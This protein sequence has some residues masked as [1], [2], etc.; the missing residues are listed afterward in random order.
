MEDNEYEILKRKRIRKLLLLK[1]NDELKIISKYKSN[2]RINSKTIQELN[3][4]YN[5]SDILLHEKSTVYSNYIKTEETIISRSIS[6]IIR[7]RI[8]NK[9]I[10]NNN[11]NNNN[12]H[13]NNNNNNNNRKSWNSN[14]L[15]NSISSKNSKNNSKKSRNKKKEETKNSLIEICSVDEDSTS[16][17]ISFFPKKIELGRKKLFG[18]K[19][20]QRNNE[21]IKNYRKKNINSDKELTNQ[22]IFIKSTKL[23]PDINLHKLIEKITSI[24]NN[25][26]TEGIIRENIKK[27][28]QYCYQLRKK[29]KKVKKIVGKRD[30]S[31]RKKFKD[32]EKK[33]EREISN[34]R[35]RNTIT[36]KD[37]EIFKH[38]FFVNI[39]KK[40]ENKSNSRNEIYKCK[41]PSPRFNN[42]NFNTKKKSTGKVIKMTNN[43]NNLKLN[44]RY[45]NK[46]MRFFASIKSKEKI[47]KLQSMNECIGLKIM[48]KL[49]KKKIKKSYKPP[50]NVQIEE[51]IPTLSQIPKMMM[52][53]T[54]N[55]MKLKFDAN[56]I[57]DDNK[58]NNKTKFYKKSLNKNGSIQLVYSKEHKDK[59][60]HKYFNNLNNKKDKVELHDNLKHYKS[61]KKLRKYELLK[62]EN[63]NKNED[64]EEIIKLKKLSIIVDSRRKS[65]KKLGIDSPDR[66]GY[67]LSNY[68]NYNTNNNSTNPIINEKD[69]QVNRSFVKK[70]KKLKY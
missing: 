56:N 68:T 13:N 34:R 21:S 11:N 6:P 49:H 3:A 44:H 5:Q 14:N 35:R 15:R 42:N 60:E 38:S 23:N 53:S 55:E 31:S 17:V 46:N 69:E 52:K 16:P 47:H 63:E 30:S 25:E 2:I 20:K 26:S 37:K 41:S 51:P 29:K 64:N 59:G 50:E 27:L 67:R 22:N 48:N 58:K 19:S 36:N 40:M 12:N 28:R 24:K 70:N 39:Q 45:S 54:I 61:N 1:I 8:V 9:N 7:S 57:D 62:K 33:Q 10:I 4:V 43:L 65:K 18:R 32:K 66:R